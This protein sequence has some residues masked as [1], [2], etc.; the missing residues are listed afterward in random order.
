MKCTYTKPNGDKCRA[1]AMTESEYCFSHNP[2]TRDAHAVA[3]MKGG[4]AKKK[5]ELDLAPIE[6]RNP[7]DVV[8]VLEDTVNGV[9]DGSIPPNVANTLAY[10]CS[11]VLRAME[12]SN[13]DDRLE[14][15]ESVLLQRKVSK[16]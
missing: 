4:K 9:R 8:T 3:V 14:L 7:K 16:N 13:I 11:H 2:D 5:N 1:N 6:L 12:A 10:V 15:V